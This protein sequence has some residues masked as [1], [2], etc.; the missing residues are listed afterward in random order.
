MNEGWLS[1]TRTAA[2]VICLLCWGLW[3]CSQRTAP[4]RPLSFPERSLAKE[5]EIKVRLFNLAQF[6]CEVGAP[7]AITRFGGKPYAGE[8]TISAAPTEGGICW[9]LQRGSKVLAKQ[10]SRVLNL[11]SSK[12]MIVRKEVFPTTT[13]RC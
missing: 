12:P 3:G 8:L 6:T 1:Y 2:L 13:I 9:V 10:S 11:T 4:Q 7:S 5:P